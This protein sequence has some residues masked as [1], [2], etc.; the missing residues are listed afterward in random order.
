ML[1][2]TGLLFGTYYALG[3]YTH[4]GESIKVPDLKGLTYTQIKEKLSGYDLNFV[5]NDSTFIEGKPKGI[6]L[7]QYPEADAQVK[8]GRK[9]LLKINRYSIPQI[10]MPNIIDASFRQA[11]DMLESYGLKLGKVTYK[12]DLAENA[13][14]GMSINGKP[15]KPGDKVFRTSYVD[16]VVG[17]GLG[18]T[19]IP[20]PNLIGLTLEEAT[21][22]LKGSSLNIGSIVYDADVTDKSTAIIYKTDPISVDLLNMNNLTDE[23]KKEKEK[24]KALMDKMGKIENENKKNAEPELTFEV[25]GDGKP[26]YIRLGQ[27]VDIFLSNTFVPP[28]SSV[29]D[30]LPNL[31]EELQQLENQDAPVDS[32]G[33]P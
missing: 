2:L 21:Y 1:I 13:I 12:P 17:D 19:L 10:E 22:I 23:E 11:S 9:I 8:P 24:E 20:V 31:N 6:V 25:L 5:L 4:H 32:N 16:L 14:L 30:Q 7:D 33:T 18:N 3:Y 27:P 26:G 15:V 29:D 28:A